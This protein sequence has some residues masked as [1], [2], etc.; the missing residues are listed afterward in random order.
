MSHEDDMSD[1]EDKESETEPEEFMDAKSSGS[2]SESDKIAAVED[3]GTSVDP[4]RKVQDYSQVMQRVT[5]AQ[6]TK[7]LLEEE[8]RGRV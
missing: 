3:Q 1:E 6:L 7:E 4:E 5:L 2:D 8:T